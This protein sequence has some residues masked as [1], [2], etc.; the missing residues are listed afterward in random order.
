MTADAA[1]L[2]AWSNDIGY[3]DVFARQVLA[4]GQ[5]G[6]VLVGLSTSGRSPNLLRA[7]AA[8]RERG[9]TTVA[10]LGGSGGDL[11]DLADVA[12]TVPA[13]RATRIQEVQLLALHLICELVEEGM[14]GEQHETEFVVVRET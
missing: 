14:E 2:T 12:V 9:L 13:S 3:E 5:P 10:L 7:F 8:A 1:L 11:H 6:D 4:F